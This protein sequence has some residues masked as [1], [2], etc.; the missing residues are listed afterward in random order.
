MSDISVAEY[1]GHPESFRD[2][3]KRFEILSSDQRIQCFLKNFKGD[4]MT[5]RNTC[6]VIAL[7]VLFLV[8]CED[9]PVTNPYH[10]D[11]DM[12]NI[13]GTL[14][15]NQLTDSSVKLQWQRSNEVID[16]YVIERKTDAAGQFAHL[17]EVAAELSEYTDNGLLTSE[18]FFY[19]VTGYN[20][21]NHTNNSIEA[22]FQT[23]FTA[24]SDFSATQQSISSVNLQWAHECS[25]ETGYVLERREIDRKIAGKLSNST[26]NRK[27][28]SPKEP[29]RNLNNARE[30]ELVTNLE[31]NTFSFTDTEILPNHI[32][33]YR[34][35]AISA[36]NSTDY[37]ND[38]ITVVF[39]SPSDLAIAQND[40]HTFTLS[41]QDNSLGESGFR[42]ER[43]I[44][45]A[46]FQLIA[47]TGA[48]T[49]LYT[50]DIN[51]RN[52]Y[53][54]V[55]YRICGYC[56]SEISGFIENQ[57]SIS[58]LPVQSLSYEKILINKIRLTWQDVNTGEDGFRIQK[59]VNGQNWIELATT[60]YL[61]YED[62]SA[63]INQSLKYRVAPY[64]GNNEVDYVETDLIDNT[65]S[66]PTD[67]NYTKP[68][69]HSIQLNWQ[70][71]IAGEQGFK[72]DKKVG[73]GN[74]VTAF[75]TVEENVTTWTD[76]A[77]EVNQDLQYR[78]YAYY[79]NE[80]S[81]MLTT[82]EI[83]NTLPAPTN[84]TYTKPNVHSILL[85]WQENINGE[86]GF[87]IDK[88]VGT[89]N[90]VMAFAT[91][92]NITTWTDTAAEVNQVVQYKAYAYY[93]NENSVKLTTPEIDNSLPAPQNFTYTIQDG[94]DINLTWTYP[95]TGIDG[96]TLECKIGSGNWSVLAGNI[97]AN[98]FNYTDIEVSTDNNYYYRL[99]AVYNTDSSAY[100]NTVMVEY[101]IT[102][103]DGNVYY[104]VY[105]GNQ[106][107]MAENL[108]VAHYR[109]GDAILN[110]TDNTTW[111]NLSTGAYCVYN[112]QS[113][114]AD[115]YGYLYNWY[116]VGDPRG[117]APEGWRVPSDDD[118][119]VLEMYLGMTQSQA[120]ALGYRG[121][122]QGSQLAGR[123]D[124]WNNGDLEN[125]SQ[126]G[127]S[128]F[129]LLSGGDRRD[130]NGNFCD[131]GIFG[132]LWSYPEYDIYS[133]WVRYLSYTSTQVVRDRDNKNCGY[134][135]RCIKN[136][137]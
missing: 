13:S 38:E 136:S 94:N 96:F 6:L 68:N 54:T 66:A 131:L 99:K 4:I 61:F 103:I 87:K 88:K 22:D 67:L 41:W 117:L 75:A 70:Q 32:Y 91:V 120:D 31:E 30:F 93:G 126:F 113:A 35:R 125:D 42:I 90:W 110:I 107:W 2:S 137:N 62:F 92:E 8:S 44:D 53:Y 45:D 74:W 100:T 106:I 43:K 130:G 116:A 108:K 80:N 118:I 102:D 5:L 3:V 104:V 47:E 1:A 86:Q 72:I 33:E 114:N 10:P 65:F 101:L 133:V 64:S 135:V 132:W 112:N 115:T 14:S 123:A 26:Q 36:Y 34:M 84:L 134:S 15:I 73:I 12:G 50:D 16:R 19:R 56:E 105:I 57:H 17:A 124:L 51:V 29:L 109:N 95:T 121:T 79:G 40:V 20:D 85:S 89:G 81:V 119:K 28:S 128:G 83:D 21:K 76:N 63:E 37:R 111:T 59:Q 49:E 97:P 55:T 11:Y 60:T 7:L 9:K 48:N 23:S 39:Q 58:F 69:I 24:I 98:T 127:S 25:Y 78:V 52:T 82:P 18:K 71:D 129:N 46:P 122:N 77:A 27:T